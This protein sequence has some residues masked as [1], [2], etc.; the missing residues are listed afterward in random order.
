MRPAARKAD[1]IALRAAAILIGTGCW[2]PPAGELGVPPLG[3]STWMVRHIRPHGCARRAV[4]RRRGIRMG[5]RQ[6]GQE[7]ASARRAAGGGRAGAA[8]YAR[9]G[10]PRFEALPKRTRAL[11]KVDGGADPQ[12]ER[13]A[14]RQA[15]AASRHA[16]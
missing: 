12:V 16:A 15:A 14:A 5:C 6:L 7:L 11:R 1:L 2:W 3:T 8:Q 10:G 4:R 13:I 9:G